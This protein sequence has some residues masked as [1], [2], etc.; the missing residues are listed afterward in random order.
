LSGSDS[1]SR[2]TAARDGE[3]GCFGVP[4][5]RRRVAEELIE[6]E[7]LEQEL[8][9]VEAVRDLEDGGAKGRR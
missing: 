8:R 4:E 5:A 1:L 3:R 7:V 2:D 6:P 9:D